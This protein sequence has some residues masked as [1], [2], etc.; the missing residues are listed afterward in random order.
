[1][2]DTSYGSMR[3]V[4]AHTH[5]F[6]KSFFTHLG[7]LAGVGPDA[8]AVA[9]KLAWNEP[10]EQPQD[11]ARR[12]TAELD[13]HGVDRAIAIHTLPGDLESAGK[14]VASSSG[15]LVGFAQINPLAEGAAV[16]AQRAVEEYGF[17]GIALF[18]AMFRFSMNS[19]AV[20]AML[21]IANRHSLCVFVHC[22]VLKVGFRTQMGIPSAFDSS[23]SNPL[24]LQRPAIEFPR[25][26]FIVPHMGSGLF[27]ELLMV[28]D[29]CPNIFT[30][31]SAI[32]GWARYLPGNMTAADVLRQAIR[33][34]SSRRILFGSDSSF[35]PRGWRRDIFDE[36]VM[37]FEE[38]ELSSE[39]VRHILA[40]NADSVL[41]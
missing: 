13:R 3:V 28:A 11:T 5:F 12:W 7:T 26:K 8:S 21:E 40:E 15:R 24:S 35:F 22:G 17:R 32:A 27:R 30:D 18:P 36:Q 19:D 2:V 10:D 6:P 29:Q 39:Q 33:V 16:A 41:G 34:M 23:F 20:F 38:A 1:M 9:K 14:G 4:D 37:T 31:T 25:A